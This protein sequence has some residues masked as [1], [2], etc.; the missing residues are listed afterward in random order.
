MGCGSEKD[1]NQWRVGAGSM[2]CMPKTTPTTRR[3]FSHR[4]IEAMRDRAYFHYTRYKYGQYP[5]ISPQCR[6]GLISGYLSCMRLFT[7]FSG[8]ERVHKN[9]V[10]E[11]F[12]GW[13]SLTKA[14]P[15]WEGFQNAI[16]DTKMSVQEFDRLLK[17]D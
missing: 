6:L 15:F 7:R 17:W 11:A 4:E 9:M 2:A 13:E 12:E 3:A 10:L 1:K 5:S 14:T 8:R 16:G